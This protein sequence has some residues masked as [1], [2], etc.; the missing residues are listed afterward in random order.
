MIFGVTA[1]TA[2][3]SMQVLRTVFPGRLISC[4]VN[5]S[6]PTLLP[7]LAVPDRFLWGYLK[8]KIY[9]THHT[10]IDDLKE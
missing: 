8:S 7:D 1:H 6:W 2:L 5:I 3:I 4:F 10:N 9:V